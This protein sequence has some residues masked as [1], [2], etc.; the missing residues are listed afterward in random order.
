MN[1]PNNEPQRHQPRRQHRIY[2]ATQLARHEIDR[3]CVLHLTMDLMDA[4]A[5]PICDGDLTAEVK[6]VAA[7]LCSRIIHVLERAARLEPDGKDNPRLVNSIKRMNDVIGQSLCGCDDVRA[8]I[9]MVMV[10]VAKEREALNA[11]WNKNINDKNLHAKT[12]GW[13]LLHDL[14][15]ELR[16]TIA[17]VA[18]APCRA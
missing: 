12:L 15:A 7:V 6:T 16:D 8:S 1:T 14:L 3:L 5:A 18:E 11:A 17:P 2:A 10:R 9:E 4:A 13:A